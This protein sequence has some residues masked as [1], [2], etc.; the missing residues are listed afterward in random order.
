M[1]FIRLEY[2][3]IKINL[4]LQTIVYIFLEFLPA[5]S[6]LPCSLVGTSKPVGVVLVRIP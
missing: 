2:T 4:F 6:G 5:L 1:I 3:L